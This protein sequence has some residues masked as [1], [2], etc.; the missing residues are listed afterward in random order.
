MVPTCVYFGGATGTDSATLPAH[1][2]GDLIVGYAFR[3]SIASAPG[4][5]AGFTS[6]GTQTNAAA[7][8]GARVG[9]RVA[10][11][12]NTATGTWTGAHKCVF[13]IYS[14]AAIGSVSVGATGDDTSYVTYGALSPSVFNESS[15]IIG[16]A[17]HSLS[18]SLETPPTGMVNRQN[19]SSA[20]GEAAAHESTAGRFTWPSTN[21]E[22][23]GSGAQEGWITFMVEIKSA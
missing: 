2:V 13:V 15:L 19:A 8:V 3:E 5:G 12:T 6:L 21:V 7:L 18:C 9:Y 23:G 22:V 20:A 11:V 10:T 4:L 1:A 17:G 16:L 14:G